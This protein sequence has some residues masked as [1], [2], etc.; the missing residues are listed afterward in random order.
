MRD[1]SLLT[2]LNSTITFEQKIVLEEII[3]KRKQH[4]ASLNNDIYQSFSKLFFN[5]QYLF[6]LIHDIT[7]LY[8]SYKS[9]F[10]KMRTAYQ[11]VTN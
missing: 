3:N 11:K 9:T 6:T 10:K 1:T 7:P 4:L 5:I 8:N 2:H